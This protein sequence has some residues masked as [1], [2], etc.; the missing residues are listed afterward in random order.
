LAPDLYHYRP[1]M[2]FLVVCQIDYAEG[3]APE[4]TL[5]PIALAE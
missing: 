5:D 4:F 1:S 3:S 2:Q